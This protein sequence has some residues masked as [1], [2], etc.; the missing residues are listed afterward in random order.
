MPYKQLERQGGIK[1]YRGPEMSCPFLT[2]LV[3]EHELLALTF[4]TAGPRT[5]ATSLEGNM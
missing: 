2:L 3:I 1:V 5:S 4:Y